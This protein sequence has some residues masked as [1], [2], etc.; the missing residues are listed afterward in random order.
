ML[1]IAVPAGLLIGLLLGA[2]GGGGSILTVAVLVC[3]LHREPHAATAGLRRHQPIRRHRA[4]CDPSGRRSGALTLEDRRADGGGHS[5]G[6]DGGQERVLGDGREDLVGHAQHDPEHHREAAGRVE[7]RHHAAQ[8]ETKPPQA[9]DAPSGQHR[10][11]LPQPARP[12]RRRPRPGGPGEQQRAG[13]ATAAAGNTAAAGP[14]APCATVMTRAVT[15]ARYPAMIAAP[16]GRPRPRPLYA[17]ASASTVRPVYH[18]ATSVP[19]PEPGP[20]PARAAGISSPATTLIALLFSAVLSTAAPRPRRARYTALTAFGRLVTTA[21]TSPP[22]TISATAYRRPTAVTATS[23]TVLAPTTAI[24][25]PA[26]ATAFSP[27]PPAGPD[28]PGQLGLLLVHRR[29]Q[30]ADPPGRQPQP[31][32][33]RAAHAQ[34]RHVRHQHH[35]RSASPAAGATTAATV[36]R[37]TRATHTAG[38]PDRTTTRRWKPIHPATTAASPSSAARL[39][40]LDPITTPAPTLAWPRASAVTAE[41][42][43]GASATSA[44][45]SPATPRRTRPAPQAARAARPAASSPPG[46][47][48]PRRR[49]ARFAAFRHS[50]ACFPPPGSGQ[51]AFRARSS[52]PGRRRI[53]SGRRLPRS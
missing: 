48:P 26:A 2:L 20:S 42:I 1:P 27:G 30:P 38:T 52:G 3:L 6:R 25:A 44:A 9:A 29:H 24:S 51:M 40:T 13:P 12:A 33:P 18:A 53:R 45:T 46:S 28:R 43:S 4:G 17:R 19:C 11:P 5:D 21:S 49:T 31:L 50:P 7:G 36:S 16:A 23:M 41:V 37:H 8:D 35:G 39:N 47:P 15:N 34:H 14:T 32:H 22:V 10:L